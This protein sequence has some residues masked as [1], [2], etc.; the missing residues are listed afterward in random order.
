MGA[1][2][3]S[4]ARKVEVEVT[5]KS[6]VLGFFEPFFSPLILPPGLN[7][8]FGMFFRIQNVTGKILR[9]TSTGMQH[10]LAHI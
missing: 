9:I 3:Q 1:E 2:N 6:S 7:L 4:T 8:E 5:W 10:S